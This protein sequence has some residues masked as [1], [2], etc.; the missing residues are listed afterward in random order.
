MLVQQR[1]RLAA[2]IEPLRR[3]REVHGVVCGI[4]GIALEPMF[5]DLGGE[6]LSIARFDTLSAL[7]EC[8]N[9]VS[10]HRQFPASYLFSAYTPEVAVVMHG[11]QLRLAPDADLI[12]SGRFDLIR[13]A[14]DSADEA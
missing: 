11:G 9:T 13:A 8:A 3:V 12:D 1:E 6:L 4:A 2:T 5:A 7:Q 14:Q 10:R